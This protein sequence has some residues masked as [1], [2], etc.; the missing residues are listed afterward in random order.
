MSV[1]RIADHRAGSCKI[2]DVNDR[3][4][5]ITHPQPDVDARE[6]FRG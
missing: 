5:V 3:L 1:H 2:V 6:V 4:L